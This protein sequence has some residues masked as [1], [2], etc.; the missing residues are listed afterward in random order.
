ML[1]C[2]SKSTRPGSPE[3][4]LGR[5]AD[6]GRR[7]PVCLGAGR[8]ARFKH[9]DVSDRSGLRPLSD[10]SHPPPHLL[11]IFWE[12]LTPSR[13]PLQC[14]AATW[15]APR[16]IRGGPVAPCIA[17]RCECCPGGG[18]SGPRKVGSL[19][20]PRGSLDGLHATSFSS[21][22][23]SCIFLL[24]AFYFCQS[25]LFLSLFD[26]LHS[27]INFQLG[28]VT[29]FSNYSFLWFHQ[30]IPAQIQMSKFPIFANNPHKD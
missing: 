22:A 10:F 3:P 9:S 20:S 12:T 4:S 13:A 14:A 5:S 29:K 24:L 23:Y 17:P 6:G 28:L 15:E 19:R 8:R 25:C 18:L 1:R 26:Q 21:T 16:C 7:V 30:I 2:C 27:P 11:P